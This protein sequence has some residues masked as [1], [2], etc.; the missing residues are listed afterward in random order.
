MIWEQDLSYDA[1]GTYTGKT[2]TYTDGRVNKYD[3]DNKLIKYTLAD[4]RYYVYDRQGGRI[5]KRVLNSK[6]GS[7]IFTDDYEY[8][9]QGGLIGIM[10]VYTDG[11][12]RHYDAAA[13]TWTWL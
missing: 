9:A 12:K 1:N 13:E 7:V 10:R 5:I 6:S 8:N 3:K 2:L 4:G 11:R